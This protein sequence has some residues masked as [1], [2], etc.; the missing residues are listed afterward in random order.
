VEKSPRL[1]WIT[2]FLTVAYDGAIF[3]NVL[4]YNAVNFLQ[5]LAFK[6]KTT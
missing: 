4:Y 2:Q 6:E 5:R 3:P 1:N